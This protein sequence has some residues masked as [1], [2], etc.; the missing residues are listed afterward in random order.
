MSRAETLT[1]HLK[2]YDP[3][4]F[5]SNDRRIGYMLNPKQ[6]VW[7]LRKNSARPS[8][9]HLVFSL[10]D[11]WTMHGSPREWGIEVV[12]SRLRAMDLWRDDGVIRRLEQDYAK[13]EESDKRASR[14][15]I[16]SFLLEFRRDFAKATNHINT[17]LLPNVDARRKGDLRCR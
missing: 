2:Q 16:E 14:N 17:S 6:S 5:A 12:L 1:K 13:T 4:L 10:T 11:N 7:V 3:S 15:N 9:P 8:E